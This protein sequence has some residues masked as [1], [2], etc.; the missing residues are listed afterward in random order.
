M[1]TNPGQ[2]DG[3]ILT[4]TF[5]LNGRLTDSGLGVL[6]GAVLLEAAERHLLDLQVRA[7][8]L[9]VCPARA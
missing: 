1:T 9:H 8:T 3:L 6:R 2:R 5:T 4:G 7:E